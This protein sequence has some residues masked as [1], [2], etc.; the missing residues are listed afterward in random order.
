MG[1]TGA[2]MPSP[3]TTGTPYPTSRIVTGTSRGVDCV[4]VY[5]DDIASPD[6]QFHLRDLRSLFTL[7]NH[8]SITINRQKSRFGLPEV[9]YLGH[10]VTPRECC[11]C[12]SGSRQS[13]M[14]RFQTPRLPSSGTWA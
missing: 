12:P 8:H 4:F 3:R 11:P 14:S 6:P 1:I 10:M 13:R 7:L 5:L 2:S 9:T